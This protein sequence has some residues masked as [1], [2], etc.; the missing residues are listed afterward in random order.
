MEN[1]ENNYFNKSKPFKFG[2]L[3]TPFRDSVF[4][5]GSV[6]LVAALLLHHFAEIFTG[7]NL[8]T[9]IGGASFWLIYSMSIAYSL[10]LLTGK[11]MRV[12]WKKQP[13]E[14]QSHRFLLWVLGLVGCFALNRD[15]PIFQESTT[16]LTVYLMLAGG[17][18]FLF[19]WKDYV[20]IIFQKVLFLLL[21]ISSILFLYFSI[22]LISIY[23]IG[24][25]GI[26]FLGISFH[27]FIPLILLVGLIV[28]FVNH[29]KIFKKP[30]L[31]GIAIPM[32]SSIIF[33]TKWISVDNTLRFSRND[34]FMTSTDEL[35]NWVLLAQK[36]DTDFVTERYLKTDIVYQT[37]RENFDFFPERNFEEIRQHD[38]LVMIATLLS[39]KTQIP[40]NERIKL[41]ELYYNARHNSEERL[42]S[43]RDLHTENIITQA[44][45]YPEYRIAYTEKTIS[46]RN[47]ER[48]S[49]G[50]QEALYTF[51]VPEGSAVSSL[52]LWINGREEKAAL[53]TQAKADSAYKS[54]V[55]VE[56][57]DPSVV[58]W[59]EGNRIV[60][61]V[62]PC[63][64][65]EN[66]TF[67]I[68]FT[69]PLKYTNE[70]LT[71]EN[72][73]F[74]G[75]ETTS[76]TESIKVEFSKDIEQ[77]DVPWAMGDKSRR[78]VSSNS[79]YRPDW[80]LVF[81]AV[82]LSNQTFMFQNKSYRL[83][84]LTTKFESFTAQNI[85][86]DLNNL[87]TKTDFDEICNSLILK[88]LQKM[89]RVLLYL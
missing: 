7:D 54:I 1:S 59:Q 63:T 52:S 46:I 28:V 65:K 85:Y 4:L 38:P 10:V 13:A 78:S 75:P 6:F 87:W 40:D 68:G 30:M 42:W 15:I 55:G 69:S 83:T 3:L 45:I 26:L 76:A 51:Y 62:F 57:R 48:W 67:K 25:L 56:S 41:L 44:K 18:L 35:P 43:G 82:S 74:K 66:R 77:L 79:D 58:H 33:V 34:T 72:I 32:F 14:Y 21:G 20:P 64:P 50:Q 11:K 49:W 9:G 73:Y 31:I 39:K 5:L 19:A 23:P 60:V 53:T 47:S 89:A 16:W 88:S 17:S 22:Y 27:T 81:P 61:R 37:P 71:Y 24:I 8:D 80:H 36:M 2:D 70:R 84:N 86:L 12:F 29:W